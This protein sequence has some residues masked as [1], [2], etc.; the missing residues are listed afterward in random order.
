M[1]RTKTTIWEAL[2]RGA[3]GGAQR[4]V[5]DHLSFCFSCKSPI[6]PFI[7]CKSYTHMCV[8]LYIYE[9]TTHSKKILLYGILSMRLTQNAAIITTNQQ[10]AVFLVGVFGKC[11]QSV[12]KCRTFKSNDAQHQ[13]VCH[14]VGRFYRYIDQRGALHTN[15]TLY[16]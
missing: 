7:Q 13:L 3:G 8:F 15:G 6:Y 14:I 9:C 2:N 10:N 16:C 1:S 5:C 4:G 12:W 11:H